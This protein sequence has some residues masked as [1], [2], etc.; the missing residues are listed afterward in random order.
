MVPVMGG[1]ILSKDCCCLA[2]GQQ[3]EKSDA[4]ARH[5]G[6]RGRVPR[7]TVKQSKRVQALSAAQASKLANAVH[8]V[9]KKLASNTNNLRIE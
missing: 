5:G 9:R 4:A 6:G 3:G 2:E 8:K 7:R 1:A